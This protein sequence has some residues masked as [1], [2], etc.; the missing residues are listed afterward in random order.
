VRT[1][2]DPAAAAAG[3]RA[4]I[5][6]LDPDLP[7]A[8]V[9]PLATVAAGTMAQPRFTMLLLGAFGGL[10]LLLASIGMYGVISY[11]MTQRAREIGIRMALGG[12]RRALFAM[13]L[14]QGARL[15]GLGIAIGLVAAL[16]ATRLMTGFLYARRPIDILYVKRAIVI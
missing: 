16:G 3:V 13:V 12:Q 15:G 14:A 7:V 9:A 11:S 5:H 2:A 1:Q 6:S 10:A 4:A 8:R